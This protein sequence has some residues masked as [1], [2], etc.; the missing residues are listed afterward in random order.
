M[1]AQHRFPLAGFE[2]SLIGRFSGVPRGG[3]VLRE[4]GKTF[5]QKVLEVE[6]EHLVGE[7]PKRTRT[8]RH[9]DGEPK[10]VTAAYSAEGERRFGIK[11]NAI[12]G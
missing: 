3:E 5:I 4:V 9:I 6:V 7:P 11:L 8:A 2:V 1:R 12:P 10:M